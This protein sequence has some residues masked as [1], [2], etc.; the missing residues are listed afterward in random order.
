M[1]RAGSDGIARQHRSSRRATKPG[2]D[3]RLRRDPRQRN[4]KEGF[5]ARGRTTSLV[6]ALVFISLVMIGLVAAN[7]Q[8]VVLAVPLGLMP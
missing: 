2:P 5:R 8:K 1:D 3:L 7:F 6:L 4:G